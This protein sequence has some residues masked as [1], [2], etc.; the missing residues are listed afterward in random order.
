MQD[1]LTAHLSRFGRRDELQLNWERHEETSTAHAATPSP[2]P[3]L[4]QQVPARRNHFALAGLAV[5]AVAVHLGLAGVVFSAP[6]WTGWA[7]DAML[8][9][10]VIKLVAVTALGRHVRTRGRRHAG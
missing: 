8:A 9:M 3:A 5:L 4:A 10:A 6:R 2:T 7:V 1:L